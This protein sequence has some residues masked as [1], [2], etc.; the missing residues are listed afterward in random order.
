M[1]EEKAELVSP[2]YD[3]DY[4][5]RR[6]FPE[7]GK[8]DGVPM[9]ESASAAHY[10]GGTTYLASNGYL[11]VIYNYTDPSSTAYMYVV[12]DTLNGF[13][14]VTKNNKLNLMLTAK[15]K[16]GTAAYEF[17]ISEAPSGDIYLTAINAKPKEATMEIYKL[18]IDAAGQKMN[19]DPMIVD[20]SDK[21]AAVKIQMSSSSNYLEHSRASYTSSRNS[22]IQDGVLGILT[23]GGTSGRNTT[24]RS[25]GFQ[26]GS[27]STV[28]WS[29][30]YDTYNLHYYSIQWPTK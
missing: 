8:K 13:K 29:G 1:Y 27:Y 16:I 22:S 20:S 2:I 28:N 3:P 18:S 11:Y 12:F 9:I 30:G 4:S 14:P 6:K 10:A 17:T 21:I 26:P 23:Y 7:I 5:D 15:N 25:E 24:L 19:L